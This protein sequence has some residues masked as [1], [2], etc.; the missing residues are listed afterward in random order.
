MPGL[1]LIYVSK[2]V[3]VNMNYYPLFGVRSWNNGMCCMSFYILVLMNAIPVTVIYF[4]LRIYMS[5]SK[6]PANRII[7]LCFLDDISVTGKQIVKDAFVVRC[8]YSATRTF[9]IYLYDI[10][11]N[12]QHNAPSA[13][14][15]IAKAWPCH[16]YDKMK[17]LGIK[18]SVTYMLTSLCNP[19]LHH[20]S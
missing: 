5:E 2:A 12:V 9:N 10:C 20:H 4:Q 8:I 3:P 7:S 6:N 17:S 19:V 18:I 16:I 14:K 11:L 1:K 13:H 15:C